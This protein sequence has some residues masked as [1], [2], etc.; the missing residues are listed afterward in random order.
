[1]HLANKSHRKSAA[2]AKYVEF[3]KVLHQGLVKVNASKFP[4]KIFP[5][6]KNIK[7]AAQIPKRSLVIRGSAK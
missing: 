2:N 5:L 6:Q 7:F 4:R 1:M 3:N